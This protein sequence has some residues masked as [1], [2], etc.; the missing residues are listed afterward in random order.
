VIALALGLGVVPAA[1]RERVAAPAGTLRPCPSR[2][3]GFIA[4]PGSDTCLR[5]SGRVAGEVAATRRGSSAPLGTPSAIGHLSIDTRTATEA[6]PVRAFVRM[7][8][9]QR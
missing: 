7:G 1:G 2:G 3:A 8:T 9:G 5:V 4:V 6:G